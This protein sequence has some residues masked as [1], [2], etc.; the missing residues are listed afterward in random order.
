[1][2]IHLIES[3]LI[4]IGNIFQG[5]CIPMSWKCDSENDCGDG[6]DEG[7]FCA[8]RTCAYFQFTCPR[9]GHCIPQSW[10]CDGDNDCF[11][12]KDEEGCPPISCSS[13]Q[14]KCSNGK[15]CV[16]DSYKCDGIPDCDDASDEAGCPSLEPD[17]CNDDKQFTCQRSAHM[18]NR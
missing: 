9:S 1:M 18:M 11:D 7:D 8:E 16:H 2:R 6:S 5:R 13:Q 10:V 14:L 3:R 17:K 4:N 15:Q 12:N